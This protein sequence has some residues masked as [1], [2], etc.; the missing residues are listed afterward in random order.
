MSIKYGSIM[1]AIAKAYG[2]SSYF[3]K[4][5]SLNLFKDSPCFPGIIL[6]KNNLIYNS[7]Q[8]NLSLSYGSSRTRKVFCEICSLL[9]TSILLSCVMYLILYQLNMS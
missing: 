2:F 9:N 7:F 6:Y 5:S 4:N 8:I 1:S 3:F